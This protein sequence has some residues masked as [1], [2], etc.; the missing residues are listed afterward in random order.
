[1]QGI[2]YFVLKTLQ[3]MIGK[4]STQNQHDF[5]KPLLKEFISLSNELVLLS[6]KI[7]CKYFEDIFSDF[8]LI[9]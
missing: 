6:E 2:S 7:G 3:Y 1:M 8:T 4:T 5:F 9:S